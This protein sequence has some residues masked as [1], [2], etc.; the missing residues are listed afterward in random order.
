LQQQK[1]VFATKDVPGLIDWQMMQN[2]VKDR[3]KTSA[4]GSQRLFFSLNKAFNQWL[5]VFPCHFSLRRTCC[6]RNSIPQQVMLSL[7]VSL[8]L[9]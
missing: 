1:K 3:K 8:V 7:V 2:P 6:I 5:K 4:T 9:T